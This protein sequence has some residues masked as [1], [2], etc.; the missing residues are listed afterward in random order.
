MEHE[1]APGPDYIRIDKTTLSDPKF[2]KFVTNNAFHDTLSGEGMIESFQ[3]YLHKSSSDLYCIL[4]FGHKLNGYPKIVHG[5][6][7]SLVMD[8]IFGWAFMCHQLPPA[9]TANLTLNFK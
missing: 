2:Q 9:F 7:S 8:S 4:T 3:V 6:I 1:L 5:G